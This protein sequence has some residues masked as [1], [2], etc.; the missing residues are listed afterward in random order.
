MKTPN[1]LLALCLSAFMLS[2]HAQQAP[3]TKLVVSITK[4]INGEKQII[5]KE[6]T[7]KEEMEKYLKENKVE[8]FCAGPDLPPRLG[9]SPGCKPMVVKKEIKVETAT[10][11]EAPAAPAPPAPPTPPTLPDLPDME[12]IT[13]DITGD[14]IENDSFIEEITV[15]RRVMKKQA[16]EP[17]APATQQSVNNE[18]TRI[19][20]LSFF[21][22]P[23]AGNF[24]VR[25]K[26]SEPSDVHL[27]ILDLS[28]KSIYAHDEKNF[29]GDFEKNIYRSEL[30]AG[31]YIM[32]VSVGQETKALKI[33]VQK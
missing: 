23:N 9:L 7:S 28:G 1:L 20:N 21:P 30:P 2:G 4:N 14:V 27:E 25:F 33:I 6:F 31:T 10:K 22:N 29:S 12:I 16:V 32:N 5:K 17:P 8:P 26:V 15:I 3:Q 19:S 13:E 18:P 11:P 24:Y